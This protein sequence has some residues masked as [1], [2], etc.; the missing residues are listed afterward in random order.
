VRG[1]PIHSFN[2]LALWR[3]KLPHVKHA[4]LPPS[5]DRPNPVVSDS[6]VPASIF[7]P[8]ADLLVL[9]GPATRALSRVGIEIAFRVTV[10]H[11]TDRNLPGQLHCQAEFLAVIARSPEEELYERCARLVLKAQLM[12]IETGNSRA[13]SA[14]HFCFCT[15]I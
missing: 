1:A 5:N 3:V 13:C 15:A 7:S 4:I 2:D 9:N 11:P 8:G 10:R 14:A 6:M 12:P